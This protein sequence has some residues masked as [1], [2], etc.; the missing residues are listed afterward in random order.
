MATDLDSFRDIF[1]YGI[2]MWVYHRN[3]SATYFNMQIIRIFLLQLNII[4]FVYIHSVIIYQF[5][6]KSQIS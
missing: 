3:A 2:S 4:K 5:E 1:L 6:A